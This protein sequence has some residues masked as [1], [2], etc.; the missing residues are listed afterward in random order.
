MLGDLG[1]VLEVIM[2]CTGALL[3]PISE[4]HYTLQAA[5][6]IFMARTKDPNLFKNLAKGNL[7]AENN[8]KI[9]KYTD[10]NLIN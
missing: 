3:F 4:H 1:G 9:L 6:R 7:N 10:E 8:K 2:V 5:K